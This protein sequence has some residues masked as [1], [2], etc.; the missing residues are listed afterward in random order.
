[1]GA[2]GNGNNWYGWKQI[3]MEWE[4]LVMKTELKWEWL[5]TRIH[6]TRPIEDGTY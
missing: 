3:Q 2:I 5:D 1:M 4:L 6:E